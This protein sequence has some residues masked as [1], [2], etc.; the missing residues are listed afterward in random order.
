MNISLITILNGINKL[1]QKTLHTIF[2]ILINIYIATLILN[3][4][5]HQL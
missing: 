5:P 3:K 1:K 2:F 4:Q